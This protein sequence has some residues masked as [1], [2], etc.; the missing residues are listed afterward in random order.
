MN[1]IQY[2]DNKIQ[3]CTL[4]VDSILFQVQYQNGKYKVQQQN[5]ENS[6]IASITSKQISSTKDDSTIQNEAKINTTIPQNDNQNDEKNNIVNKQT[7]KYNT[8]KLNNI[9]NNQMN[10]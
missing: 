6:S 9:L 1:N 3:N 4:V 8:K 10:N 5:S 7:K 2:S